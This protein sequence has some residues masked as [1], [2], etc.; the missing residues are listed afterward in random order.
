MNNINYKGNVNVNI[1][2][3]SIYTGVNS[4][5]YFEHHGRLGMKWGKKNGPPYPLDYSKLSEEERAKDKQRVKEEGD[6]ESVSYKKNRSY[7]TDQE[8]NEVINR[9]QLN[10]RINQLAADSAKMKAGKS[11]TEELAEK[12]QKVSDVGFKLGS[13]LQAG[14]N[15][16]NNVAKIM[17]A[18]GDNDMPIIGQQKQKESKINKLTKGQLDNYINNIDKLQGNLSNNEVRELVQR[19]NQIKSLQ[20]LRDNNKSDADISNLE[21]GNKKVEL[22]NK[23][24]ELMNQ[25][26][27]IQGK[28]EDRM[29]QQMQQRA[30]QQARQEAQKKEQ[31]T[32]QQAQKIDYDPSALQKAKNDYTEA[33]KKASDSEAKFRK[34]GDDLDRREAAV[35]DAKLER[36][37]RALNEQ[38]QKDNYKPTSQYSAVEKWLHKSEYDRSAKIEKAQKDFAD[39]QQRKRIE[40]EERAIEEERKKRGQT[41][42]YEWLD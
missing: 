21:K 6:I 30:Q 27:E 2:H 40:S 34:T 29:R 41:W 13:A 23:R 39:E 35:N 37:T 8:I 14:T 1:K 11:K 16:Y 3:S 4:Q 9:Y 31:A 25:R 32:Q 17:N 18:L 36:A 7:F 38:M 33:V 12:L 22:E 5:P 42:A 19:A 26:A 10:S 20:S 15:V 28:Q 24:L